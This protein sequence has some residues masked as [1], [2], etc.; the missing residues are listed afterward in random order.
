M[1]GFR[2]TDRQTAFLVGRHAGHSLPVAN[3]RRQLLIELLRETGLVIPQVEMTGASAHEE[4]DHAFGGW[5]VMSCRQNS[6][7]STMRLL[8]HQLPKCCSAQPQS[9]SAKQLPPRDHQLVF[10]YW[11]FVLH[12]NHAVL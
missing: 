7:T 2:R 10:A 9:R 4:V 8:S 6:A 11:V 12:N 3:F 5:G 1:C